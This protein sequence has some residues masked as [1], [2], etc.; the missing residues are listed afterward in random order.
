MQDLAR[1]G[2]LAFQRVRIAETRYL[3]AGGRAP[4]SQA[5]LYFFFSEETLHDDISQLG[6]ILLAGWG[7]IVALS[8]AA[9]A[10]LARRILRPVGQASEAAHAL[11]EGLLET[12]LPVETDDEF[13]AWAAAFN[14]MADAL[15]ERIHALAE[16]QARERQF[17]SDVAHELRTPVTALVGEASL[18]AEHLDRLPDGARR[19]AELLVE[20]VGRM[21]RLVEELMEISRL[22]AG[23]EDV[24]VELVDLE[25]LSADL[26]R[27]RG[28]E[29]AVEFE[30]EP[31]VVETDPRRVERVL[32]NLIENAS[33]HGGPDVEVR[34]GRNGAAARVEV[35][36]SGPGIAPE[37]V[38]HVFERFY[39]AD[40]SRSGTGSGLGLAIAREN[41]R[42]LG[43]EITVWSEVGSGTHFTLTLPVSRP[44]PDRR[45]GDTRASDDGSR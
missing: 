42:L 40:P 12:R 44:L 37:H 41:A 28:F 29:G 25:A 10:I 11:A 24:Q 3:V 5:E 6:T 31:V 9:G 35:R 20:D 8:A 38:P 43:G 4:A 36:D 15:Q 45:D 14:E 18:L 39:K 22:D 7:I 33:I 26:L 30:A 21:H 34:V 16:A 19:P 23:R 13:G 1:T 2:D 32:S 17:T 27:S